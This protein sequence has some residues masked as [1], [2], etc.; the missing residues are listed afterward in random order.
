MIFPLLPTKY[1]ELEPIY[2]C[3]NLQ[4]W[5]AIEYLKAHDF[6]GASWWDRYKERWQEMGKKKGTNISEHQA[7]RELLVHLL[8]IVVVAPK[9]V[10][11]RHTALK[12][13]D[14][15]DW[16]HVLSISFHLYHHKSKQFM[17][18]F[19]KW[20]HRKNILDAVVKPLFHTHTHTKIKAKLITYM[21]VLCSLYQLFYHWLQ[22]ISRHCRYHHGIKQGCQFTHLFFTAIHQTLSNVERN[23]YMIK[24]HL[25]ADN[26]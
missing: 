9:T 23:M 22:L 1:N 18:S 10:P 21:I 24:D 16:I 4:T 5:Q 26:F 13:V 11:V 15:T 25:P 20:E 2:N 3:K 14:W 12:L 6:N 19:Y 8:P 17:R 7:L